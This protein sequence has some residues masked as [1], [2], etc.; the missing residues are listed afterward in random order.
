M[1]AADPGTGKSTLATQIAV[2]LSSANPVFGIFKVNRAVKCL[3]IQAERSII[4]T[5]ERLEKMGKVYTISQENLYITADYQQI[6][7]LKEDHVQALI[8]A[9][10]THCPGVEVIFIDPIYCMVSGGLKDDV[11]ASAFAHAMSALQHATGATLWYNHHTVKTQIHQGK[12]V[13][14]DDPFYGSQWLKAHVTGSFYLKKDGG[15]SILLRKKDNYNILP[16]SI[17]LEYDPET[18]LSFVNLSELPAIERIKNFLR[19]RDIDGKEFSFNDLAMVTKLCHR[20]LRR[21]LCHS[22]IKDRLIVVNSSKNRNLYKTS[23]PKT[24]C[25]MT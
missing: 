7:L 15:G 20:T 5:L 19:A 11:P 10:L 8:T 21:G 17:S 24:S 1:V 12:P 3:I 6:N 14:R 13:Q 18:D 25:A 9:V 23:S 22:S 4:E 2:E 16:E